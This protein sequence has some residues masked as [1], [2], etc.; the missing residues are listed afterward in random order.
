VNENAAA[1][2]EFWQSVNALKDTAQDYGHKHCIT[3]VVYDFG[4]VE[5]QLYTV[6]FDQGVLW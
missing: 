5:K 2:H 3:L 1:Y 6:Y 4:I